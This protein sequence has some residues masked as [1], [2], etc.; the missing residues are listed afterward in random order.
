MKNFIIASRP[1]TL[2]AAII[3]P[4]VAHSLYISLTSAT[5][6]YLLG[7]CLLTA[8]FIQ[9]ATNFYNDAIDFVKG[10]DNN[11]VGPL[12]VSSA[13]KSSHKDVMLWGHVCVLMALLTSIPLIMQGGVPILIL[14]FMSLYLAYGYTGGPYPLAYKGLGELFVFIFFGLVA[15]VASFY[16]FSGKASFEAWV[17]GSQVG[18]LS[19][20]LIAVNNFRDRFEDVKVN[21]RTLATRLSQENYLLMM[22]V[23]L[24]LPYILNLYFFFKFK[25][26]FIFVILAMPIGHKIRKIIHEHKEIGEL[27][28]AL[29]FGGIHLLVFGLLFVMGCLWNQ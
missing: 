7:M 3:P 25:M 19:C 9:L 20:V 11:R 12:R 18:L 22:D 15:V 24:F 13:G 17:L 21:K 6:Y 29:K 10:A 2:V 27:N 28:D 1:K 5:S 16:L 23:F 8:F 14:G 4:V 26:S